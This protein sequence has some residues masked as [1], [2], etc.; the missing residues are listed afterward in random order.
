M[1]N[2]SSL[3]SLLLNV[4]L[5]VLFGLRR[6]GYSLPKGSLGYF[7]S[8]FRINTKTLFTSFFLIKLF[9]G[10]LLIKVFYSGTVSLKLAGLCWRL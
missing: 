10:G 5:K 1:E 7:R 6:Q 8:L 3:F 4:I 2:Q 9:F